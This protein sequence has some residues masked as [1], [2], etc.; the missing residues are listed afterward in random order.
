MYWVWPVVSIIVS[1]LSFVVAWRFYRYVNDMVTADESI[2]KWGKLIR[3]GAFPF[4]APNIGSSLISS[5]WPH[6]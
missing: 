2:Q 4:S 5:P 1:L 3:E 6:F